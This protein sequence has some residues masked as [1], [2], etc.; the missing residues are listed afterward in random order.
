M[1]ERETPITD[2]CKA[3]RAVLPV[4]PAAEIIPE[5]SEAKK[6]ELGRLVKTAGRMNVPVIVFLDPVSGQLS[7]GDG[8]S[9]LDALVAVGIRFSVEI[10]SDTKVIIT[11]KGIEIPE[12]QIISLV[13]DF[14]PYAFV[15]ATNVGRR[16][17][18]TAEKRQ[19]GAQLLIAR[20]ELADRAIAKLA[21]IDH[22]TVAAI[23]KEILANGEIPHNAER[24]EKNGRRARGRKPGRTSSKVPI[25]VSST[26]R[27]DDKPVIPISATKTPKQ[28]VAPHTFRA[29]EILNAARKVLEVL[30]RPVSAP[31]YDA[32]RKEIHRVIE[33][34]QKNMNMVTPA[35]AA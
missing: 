17:L 24:V 19:I 22:K 3:W 13:G 35:K 2:A 25:G 18:S 32:A 12:P 10:T 26:A 30:S 23:R 8:R 7:L 15:A 29:M 16:H 5:Y 21:S 33:L 27:A 34:V 28:T 9:R 20:P 11:A 31:N 6:I 4:H 1:T 14:D